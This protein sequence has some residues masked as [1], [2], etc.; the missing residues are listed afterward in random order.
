[1]RSY[2]LALAFFFLGLAATHAQVVRPAPDF[3]F[4]GVGP[5]PQTLHGLH[6]QPVVLIIAPSPKDW[7]FQFQ[8]YNLTK[9]Y[10]EFANKQVIFVA[11]FTKTAGPIKSNIPIVT[12]NDGPAVASAYN[13]PKKFSIAIIGKDGNLDYQTDKILGAERVNDVI[14]NSYAVQAVTGRQ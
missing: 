10:Q 5:K 11:A 13:A 14:Q 7:L 3:S 1:M 9:R 8:V 2:L 4:P 12:A 6:G